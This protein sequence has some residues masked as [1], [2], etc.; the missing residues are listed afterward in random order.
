MKITR[1]KFEN[2]KC[3]D[4]IELDLG[5]LTVLTGA[6]SSGKSSIIYGILGSLQSGEFPFQFSPNGKYIEMGDYQEIAH[7]HDSKK[8]IKIDY[9]IQNDNTYDIETTWEMD[10]VRKM[11]LL[12]AMIIRTNGHVIHIDRS[13]KYIVTVKDIHK[14]ELKKIEMDEPVN[15]NSKLNLMAL[16]NYLN[17]DTQVMDILSF[18]FSILDYHANYISS[19]RNHPNRTYYEQTKTD[20]KVGKC[21]E[22]YTDQIILW[23][24]QKAKEYKDL[25]RHLKEMKLLQDIKSKRKKGGQYELRV[26]P[27]K[28]GQLCS[29]VDVGFGISQFLPIL[30]ADLQLGNDSTLFLSEPEIHLHPSVQASFADYIIK[31]INTTNKS[32]IIETHSE[33]FLNRLRLGIVKKKLQ[34]NDIKTYFFRNSGEAVESF[35]IQFTVDGEIKDAPEDF[36]RTYLMDVMDIAMQAGE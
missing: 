1:L 17:E 9:S 22:Y 11:P 14:N 5:R 28:N 30:V 20:L 7:N 16:E 32:Y 24:T 25:I 4:N 34:E 23:E 26:K 19:L 36:F 27:Q 12:K 18:D 13:E 31:Q 33:Y 10:Q 29:L 2:I 35:P 3:F 21:G 15:W 8:I 6:N